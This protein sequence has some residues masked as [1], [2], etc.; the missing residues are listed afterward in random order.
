MFM[1]EL[2]MNEIEMNMTILRR[3]KVRLPGHGYHG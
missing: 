1:E 3:R 2:S